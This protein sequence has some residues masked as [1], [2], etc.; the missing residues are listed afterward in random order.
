MHLMDLVVCED[1][2]FEVGG[3]L[4]VMGIIDEGLALPPMRDNPAQPIPFKVALL[5]RIMRAVQEPAPDAF[6][7]KI[8]QDFNVLFKAEGALKLDGPSNLLRF[9]FQPIILQ[10]VQPGR[11]TVDFQLL[12]GG[13]PVFDISTLGYGFNVGLQAPPPA[14]AG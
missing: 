4:S 1:I 11:L 3:K 8:E 7:L 2:R 9:I 5:L 10:G 14:P 13:K 12:T 6:K